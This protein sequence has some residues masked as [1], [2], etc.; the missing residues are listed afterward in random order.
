MEGYS[1]DSL[2]HQIASLQCKACWLVTRSE[3]HGE[4]LRLD[5][6]DLCRIQL[7]C[8]AFLAVGHSIVLHGNSDSARI[9]NVGQ[10][11]VSFLQGLQ[12]IAAG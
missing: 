6:G 10:G 5:L 8:A 7:L 4:F 11:T 9:L 1:N 3:G 2:N 12:V